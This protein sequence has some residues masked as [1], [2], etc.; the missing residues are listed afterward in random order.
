MP[1]FVDVDGNGSLDLIITGASV[2]GMEIRALLNGAAKG[3]AAQY[4]LT[5]ATLWPIPDRLTLGDLMTV[6]DVDRDGK[7]DVLIGKEYGTI[8]YFRN[9]GSS[10]TPVFQLQNQTFGGF[11]IDDP[12][13]A[14]ARSI[15]VT[16]LNG[17]QQN[18]L[19]LAA[20]NGTVRVYQFPNPVDKAL[21]LLDSL[22]SI[23]FPGTGL[24]AAAADLDGDELPDLML[25]SIAGGMRY[26]KNTSQR[27]VTGIPEEPT[28][29]WAFPNPTDR[30]LTIRPPY[31]G[32]IDVVSLSG[33][34]VMSSQAVLAN[35]ETV[36]DLQRITNGMYLIRLSGSN[37]SPQVQKVLLLK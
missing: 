24:I 33:Q 29:P 11:T 22:P 36:V 8:E 28:G 16:D 13:Y 2:S 5:G 7:L 4:S 12:T 25:G 21:T 6:A 37:R 23:G 15:V 9:T 17:D 10:T 30:Y 26:L 14:R 19:I 34:V 1:S 27:V 35:V 32:Q 20:D 31:D 18:E 3:A